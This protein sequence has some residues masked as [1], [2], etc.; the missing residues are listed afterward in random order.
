MFPSQKTLALT[1]TLVF[2][3]CLI[4]GAASQAESADAPARISVRTSDLDFNHTPDALVLLQRIHDAATSAC[5]GTPDYRRLR[6]AAAFEHCRK[7][8]IWQAVRDAHQPLVTEIAN[9]ESLP[10]RLAVR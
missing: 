9:T 8:V 1:L 4:G 6:E 5:G 10:M 3:T 7:A 2:S